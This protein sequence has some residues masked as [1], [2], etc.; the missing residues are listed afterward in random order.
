[1]KIGGG[2]AVPVVV[3]L[4]GWGLTI[5]RWTDTVEH[6]AKTESTFGLRNDFHRRVVVLTA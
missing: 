6:A 4:H 2:L 5:P 1:M 3:Q